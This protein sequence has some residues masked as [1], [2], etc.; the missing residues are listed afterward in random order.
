MVVDATKKI[1]G[2]PTE[3]AMAEKVGIKKEMV[4][5]INALIKEYEGKLPEHLGAIEFY[6]MFEEGLKRGG[7]EPD[8]KL[9]SIMPLCRAYIHG[10][11]LGKVM[12]KGK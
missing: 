4:A 6:Y 11:I 2:T 12:T 7:I 9:R 1:E 8:F 5:A 10:Y 3:F